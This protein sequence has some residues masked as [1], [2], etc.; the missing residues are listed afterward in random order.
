VV[1]GGGTGLFEAAAD[2]IVAS[3][4]NADRR[5]LARQEHV[6]ESSVMAPLLAQF[7][8]T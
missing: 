8:S 1:T 4:P 2:A 3:M 6:V 5:I 7:F